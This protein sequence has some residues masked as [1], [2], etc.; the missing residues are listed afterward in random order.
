MLNFVKTVH[1]LEMVDVESLLS[2][3]AH[4]LNGL[5]VIRFCQWTCMFSTCVFEA[6]VILHVAFMYSQMV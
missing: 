3:F 1:L 6:V 2:D 4:L 5:N